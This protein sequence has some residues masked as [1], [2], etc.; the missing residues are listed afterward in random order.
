LYHELNENEGLRSAIEKFS[1]DDDV[2]AWG[3][4]KENIHTAL[5][6]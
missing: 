4:L 6:T 3:A 5:K 2:P 1:A